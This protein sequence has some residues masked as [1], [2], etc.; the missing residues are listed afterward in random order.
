[1]TKKKQ[2][3]K[4]ARSVTVL[5]SNAADAAE[6]MRKY[7]EL[8]ESIEKMQRQYYSSDATIERI[9][10]RNFWDILRATIYKSNQK[11]HCDTDENVMSGIAK[12]K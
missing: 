8:E 7:K 1:M 3:K 12:M 6:L 5:S 9:Q 10:A 11:R 4:S 2:H